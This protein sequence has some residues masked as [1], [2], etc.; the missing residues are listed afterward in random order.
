MMNIEEDAFLII[1][2]SFSEVIVCEKWHTYNLS[3]SKIRLIRFY[4]ILYMCV[5]SIIF[6]CQKVRARGADRNILKVCKHGTVTLSNDF[7]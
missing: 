7:V 2:I 6:K 3:P 1:C 4:P 5:H